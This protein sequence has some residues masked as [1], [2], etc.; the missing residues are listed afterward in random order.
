MPLPH[1]RRRPSH[2]SPLPPFAC[3]GP[4][5]PAILVFP[6]SGQSQGPGEAHV[7]GGEGAGCECG[8][9][10]QLT[11][12]P[13]RA[14]GGRCLAVSPSRKFVATGQM[15]RHPK[16]FVWNPVASPDPSDSPFKEAAVRVLYHD[17]PA[18]FCMQELP[19]KRLV[20]RRVRPRCARR[21][22]APVAAGLVRRVSRGVAPAG[23]PPSAPVL[24]RA[25]T[26]QLGL[27]RRRRCS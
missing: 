27:G 13:S 17:I 1:A 19:P 26:P 16:I 9:R 10:Q 23:R 25:S 21:P 24:A 3:L 2:L 4:K 18:I 12:E 8:T 15:G 7:G 11:R 6:C 22:R 20:E 14:G 5:N